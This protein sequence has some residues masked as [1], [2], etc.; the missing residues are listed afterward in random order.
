LKK[1]CGNI[2]KKL[3]LYIDD[4]LSFED[5]QKVAQHL[6]SCEACMLT[7]NQIKKISDGIKAMPLAPLPEDFAQSLHMRLAKES[8]TDNKNKF[9]LITEQTEK[10]P[11]QRSEGNPLRVIK[12]WNSLTGIAAGLILALLVG[13]GYY[14]NF[15]PVKTAYIDD[16]P[17]APVASPFVPDKAQPVQSADDDI[18]TEKNI[19]VPKKTSEAVKKTSPIDTP[20]PSSNSVNVVAEPSPIIAQKEEES[21]QTI[22]APV[23]VTQ[24]P[25]DG[26]QQ[27]ALQ[28]PMSARSVQIEEVAPVEPGSGGGELSFKAMMAPVAER[29]VNIKVNNL[30]GFLSQLDEKIDKISDG[31][32]IIIY[33]DEENFKIILKIASENDALVSYNDNG[34]GSTKYKCIIS[35]K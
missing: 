15:Q 24:Q 22:E 20:K 10:I 19:N 2:E 23:S 18:K 12:N 32:N 34:E 31:E 4:E 9:V 25:I 33:A 1:N 3:S 16:F 8:I 30:D 35:S 14:K 11:F 27:D 28:A 13:T 5:K 17:I 6:Q 29:T 26:V 21:P 7:Y